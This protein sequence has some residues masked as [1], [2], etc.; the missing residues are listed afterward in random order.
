MREAKESDTRAGAR[1]KTRAPEREPRPRQ[2]EWPGR[3]SKRGVVKNFCGIQYTGQ[4]QSAAPVLGP[5]NVTL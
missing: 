2:R 5:G 4:P 1:R 3:R